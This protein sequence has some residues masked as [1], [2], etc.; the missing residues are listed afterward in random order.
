MK[1][2]ICGLR[3][4]ENIEEISLTNVD[5]VGFNFYRK[6]KRFVDHTQAF[7]LST[8]SKIPKVGVFVN[9]RIQYLLDMVKIYG[10]D[11]VQLHGDETPEYV[12][13]VQKEVRVIKVF[14]IATDKDFERI[15]DYKNCEYFLFDTKSKQRGGSG[16]QFDWAL[17]LN[18]KGDTPFFLAGGIS[19]HDLNKIQNIKHPNLHGLDLNSKFEIEPGL[20]DVT[21]IKEFIRLLSNE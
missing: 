11:Y 18:Y 9:A 1:I 21:L 17:L 20:K 10:L 6:S 12:N 5:Y 8:F 14:S 16:V 7:R 2:K 13:E 19:L 15:N 4:P 3:A